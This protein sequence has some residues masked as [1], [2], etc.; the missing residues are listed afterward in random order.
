MWN[1]SGLTL[2]RNL[3]RMI[4]KREPSISTTSQIISPRLYVQFRGRILWNNP[5][6]SI[7]NSQ[8]INKLKAKLKNWGNIHCTCGV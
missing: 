6:L 1:L 2:M 5:L 8:T 4:Y 7:K 3:F